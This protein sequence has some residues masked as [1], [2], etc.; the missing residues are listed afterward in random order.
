MASYTIKFNENARAFIA[1]CKKPDGSGWHT[2]Q[3]PKQFTRSMEVDA[4]HWFIDWYNTYIKTYGVNVPSYKVTPNSKTLLTLVPKWLEYRYKDANTKP[5]T[6]NGFETSFKYWILDSGDDEYKHYSIQNHDLEKDFTTQEVIKWIDSLSN[7]Y[8]SKLAYIGNLRTFFSDCI[9]MGWLDQNMI[10]PLDKDMIKKRIAEIKSNKTEEQLVTYLIE[11]HVKSLLTVKHRKLSDFRRI[12]Y[13]LAIATGMRD[14][15]VMGLTFGDVHLQGSPE[16]KSI[17]YIDVNKQL[18]QPGK[19]PAMTY[20]DLVAKGLD[21]DGIK[22]VDNAVV[23]VPK[24]NS[25][26]LIPMHGLLVAGLQYWITTGWKLY[27]GLG[28]APE[29]TDPVFPVGGSFYNRLQSKPGDFAQSDSALLLRKD[30]KRLGLP[31]DYRGKLLNFH[32]L[33]HTFSTLLENAGIDRTRIGILLGHA[34]KST[35]GKHYVAKEVAN[36]LPPIQSLPL[37]TSLTLTY[38]SVELAP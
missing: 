5:N 32:S 22:Q 19:L 21:K 35:A 8:S 36:N 28:R 23:D 37:P 7:A 12:R 18:K 1:R 4:E 25:K 6:Y 3:I 27:T 24:R 13:L 15:E 30:L 34:E 29:A 14:N 26:R 16:S 20:R 11:E 2:K 9:G 33:R 31:I 38:G 17:P 10:N